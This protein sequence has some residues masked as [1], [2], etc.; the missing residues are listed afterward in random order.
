MNACGD[1]QR[2][3]QKNKILIGIPEL[4]RIRKDNIKEEDWIIFRGTD[5]K[6]ILSM[7]AQVTERDLGKGVGEWGLKL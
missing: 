7:F 5:L 3:L 2:N 4:T 1:Y 6:V